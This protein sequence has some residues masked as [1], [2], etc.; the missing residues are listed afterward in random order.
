MKYYIQ[1][2]KGFKRRHEGTLYDDQCVGVMEAASSD[3]VHSVLVAL[4][5]ENAYVVFQ[6]QPD[7]ETYPFGL[8]PIGN[9]RNST[10]VLIGTPKDCHDHSESIR[11]SAEAGDEM[12]CLSTIAS[13]HEAIGIIKKGQSD[14]QYAVSVVRCGYHPSQGASQMAMIEEMLTA[15]L[16]I[17]AIPYATYN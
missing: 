13:V 12:I 15:Q 5:G 16:K 6:N 1:F 11:D 7:L 2:P 3:V 14:G 4:F 17:N 9:V 8:V 10:Y